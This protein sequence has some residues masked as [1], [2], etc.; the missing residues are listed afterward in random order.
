MILQ[1]KVND[2]MQKGFSRLHLVRVH[3]HVLFL[4]TFTPYTGEDSVKWVSTNAEKWA[5]AVLS[6]N[7]E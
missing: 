6:A 7:K 4:Y 5:D 3:E 2:E 1:L